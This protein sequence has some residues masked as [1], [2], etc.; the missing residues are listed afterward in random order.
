LGA[1]TSVDLLRP[2]GCS[3]PILSEGKGEVRRMKVLHLVISAS[4][5]SPVVPGPLFSFGLSSSTGR[6]GREHRGTSST[7]HEVSI[8]PPA[9][10]TPTQPSSGRV[11]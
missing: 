6:Y 4:S 1:A 9:G 5:S 3:N 7:C 11:P 2:S 10:L 8:S